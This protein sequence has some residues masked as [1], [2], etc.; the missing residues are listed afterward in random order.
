ML[1]INHSAC[2]A[3]HGTGFAA[4]AVCHVHACYLLRV[5]GT[6]CAPLLKLAHSVLPTL[7]CQAG[8]FVSV[9]Y[10]G[11]LDDSSVFDTSRKDGRQPLE[12]QIGGGLV[13]AATH[14]FCYVLPSSQ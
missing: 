12:F 7:C 2:Q 1:S 13:R 11:T 4:S 14:T 9:H 5:C 10:T 8:D 6:V 3:F